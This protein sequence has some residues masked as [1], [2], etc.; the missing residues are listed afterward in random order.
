MLNAK[1]DFGPIQVID[2]PNFRLHDLCVLWTQASDEDLDS[3]IEVTKVL[4]G[5]FNDP[6]TIWNGLLLD[7]RN[8]QIVCQTLGLPFEYRE[9][10][11]DYLKASVYVEAK[12]F[13]R[14]H[15]TQDQKAMY[16][17]LKA[18]VDLK[19]GHGQGPNIKE[20]A[21]ANKIHPHKV[22]QAIRIA[23]D[24]EFGD[25]EESDPRVQRIMSGES[26]IKEEMDEIK[27][28]GKM[29]NLRGP[30]IERKREAYDPTEESY[31]DAAGSPVG[32]NLADIWRSLPEFVRVR[33]FVQHCQA[34]LQK[35]LHHPAAQMVSVDHVR[36]LADLA[37]D[38]D[39][40]TPNFVCPHCHGNRKCKCPLCKT[41]W[42]G[43]GIEDRL[44]CYCCQGMGYLVKEQPFPDTEWHTM[45][46]S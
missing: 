26:S 37:H 3:M 25:G 6:G 4:G 30:K 13:A 38:L 28:Q 39:A 42:L 32:S 12:N 31:Q 8:R 20:I 5:I 11:G 22:R 27:E 14:R 46:R 1:V 2:K 43:R 45:Q 36:H 33:N 7:G 10:K 19:N 35:L 44:D 18:K 9:F 15:L 29:L 34:E 17:V 23:K 16:K 41:R 24:A 21:A 40:K